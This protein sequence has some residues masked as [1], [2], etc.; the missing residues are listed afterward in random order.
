MSVH[1]RF[2]DLFKIRRVNFSFNDQT[3]LQ[4]PKTST[5]D[6]SQLFKINELLIKNGTTSISGRNESHIDIKTQ[7]FIITSMTFSKSKKFLFNAQTL[8]QIP[9]GD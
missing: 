3:L 9:R 1:Y 7:R 5:K 6:H 8:L 2:H 4:I